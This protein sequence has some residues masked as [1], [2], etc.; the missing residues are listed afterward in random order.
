MPT[1]RA[2]E[3]DAVMV[4]GID[5]DMDK[6]KD[7]ARLHPLCDFEFTFESSTLLI[8]PD[9]RSHPDARR[10]ASALT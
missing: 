3:P 4:D 5:M 7:E 2:D 8:E 1:P 9:V 10:E 6:D